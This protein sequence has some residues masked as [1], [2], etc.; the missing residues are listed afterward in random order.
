M[1]VLINRN[2]ITVAIALQD[3]ELFQHIYIKPEVVLEAALQNIVNLLLRCRVR[4]S[5]IA[6]EHDTVFWH[7]PPEVDISPTDIE[8]FLLNAYR[9]SVFVFGDRQLELPEISITIPPRGSFF[10]IH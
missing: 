10:G 8:S 1:L 5:E 4:P 9:D 2:V 7:I 3:V 6:I